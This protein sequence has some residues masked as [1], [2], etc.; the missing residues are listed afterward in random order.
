[1]FKRQ[2]IKKI[3]LVYLGRKG[4]G[5][6]YSIEM[7]ENLILQG[8][9]LQC[10]LSDQIENRK[11]WDNLKT[12][13]QALSIIYV[14]TYSNK[15]E[16]LIS[17]LLGF[18]KYSSVKSCIKDFNPNFLY[19]PMLSLL[20]IYVL[21]TRVPVVTTIHDVEQHLGEQNL[22]I[23]LLYD[24]VVK[25]S[26]KI[27]TL[28]KKFIKDIQIKYSFK[29]QDIFVIPH[30]NFT[31][32]LPENYKPDF[33]DLNYRI[34]FFGRIHP[35]KGLKVLLKAMPAIIKEYPAI[36]LRIAGNGKI[37]DAEKKLIDELSA[38]IDLHIKWISDDE[39]YKFI[40]DTDLIVLPYV[41]ASQS[42]VIP[43]AYS[44]GKTVIASNVGGL[45]EQIY[46]NTGILVSPNNSNELANT[47][48]KLYNSPNEII[49]MNKQ[50][51]KVA[52]EILTWEQSARILLENTKE[53]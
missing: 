3:S 49:K 1:M 15:I 46:E 14:N 44:F 25:R 35:Y 32:Y 34:L 18:F 23:S 39:I 17:L 5:P 19:I 48:I 10:I 20:S 29:T 51:Y 36:Q 31:H 24:K 52:H 26:Q 38:N 27:I 4:A 30:A 41:E 9:F 47:I 13:Y 22:L 43:L 42:G 45:S 12:K 2:F 50:A 11:D 6:T 16:F 8:C 7:T 33:N 21:P 40:R 28:S 37:Q 53:L